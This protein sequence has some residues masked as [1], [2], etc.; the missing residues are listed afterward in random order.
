VRQQWLWDVNLPRRFPEQA[1]MGAEDFQSCISSLGQAT[2]GCL[3]P[4][5]RYGIL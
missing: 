1:Q 5:L 4:H 2:G 3:I